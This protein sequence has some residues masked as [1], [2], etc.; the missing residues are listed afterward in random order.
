[1][2]GTSWSGVDLLE[3]FV[4]STFRSPL[5]QCNYQF[6]KHVVH[7]INFCVNIHNLPYGDRYLYTDWQR[8]DILRGKHNGLDRLD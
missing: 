7:K 2:S 3:W 1:M 8:L 6:S 4:G 5:Q